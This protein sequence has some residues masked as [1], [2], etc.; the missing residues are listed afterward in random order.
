MEIGNSVFMQYQKKG[1]GAFV[2]LPQRNVD[3][4]GGL[5][6]L[7]AAVENQND[8]FQT[9]L[10]NSIVRAIELTTGKSYRNNSRLMRI[11]TDHFV[12]AAFITASG[13]A[14]SNKEQGY[15]LRRLI[16]RGLDNFYQLEGKEITPILEL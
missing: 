5:E 2:Q 7:L 10:F 9:T 1:D 3:F 16:R 15:I 12:A 6:R 14:P 13:V 8:I 11:V 4:G